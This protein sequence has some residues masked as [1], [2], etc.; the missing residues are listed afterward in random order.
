MLV[1]GLRVRA[2]FSVKQKG[3]SEKE[4]S[5]SCAQTNPIVDDRW[6]RSFL[7]IAFAILGQ[8]RYASEDNTCNILYIC[9]QNLLRYLRSAH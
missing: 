5:T 6:Y 2:P 3:P 7:R 1:V 8:S 4:Q 9:I